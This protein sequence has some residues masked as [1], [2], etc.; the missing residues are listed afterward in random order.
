MRTLGW[1]NV[2]V[3]ERGQGMIPLRHQPF[4]ARVVV[5]REYGDQGVR[6]ALEWRGFRGGACRRRRDRDDQGHLDDGQTPGWGQPLA[7]CRRFADH[8]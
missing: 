4:T 1:E 3:P 8:P 6:R 7:A 5:A 2:A